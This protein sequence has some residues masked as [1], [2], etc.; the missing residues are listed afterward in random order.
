V[1]N[2]RR[3]LTAAA[4]AVLSFI[5]SAPAIAGQRTV[6][7]RVVGG[8]S[9][10]AGHVVDA[11]QRDADAIYNQIGVSLVWTSD[12]DASIAQPHMTL[13]VVLASE[14]DREF[15]KAG[16]RGNVLGVAPTGTGRAYIFCDRVKEL[17]RKT[18]Q[19]VDVILGR[20]IAHEL[21]HLM[22]GEGH[23]DA[24]IMQASLDY[25]SNEAPAFTSE[26]GDDIRGR[27]AAER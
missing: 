10:I 27:V 20:V 19:H 4:V 17:A 16:V 26:Q 1:A 22:L 12:P 15:A 13:R 14:V 5:G 21:G 11:A 24:G 8:Q 25:A 2:A 23:S 7:L 3:N 9:V 6:L 18:N